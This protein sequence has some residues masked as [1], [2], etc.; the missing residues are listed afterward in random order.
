MNRILSI[1]AGGIFAALLIVLTVGIVKNNGSR[2]RE[3]DETSSTVA[4]TSAQT[5]EITESFTDFITDVT[6]EISDTTASAVSEFTATERTVSAVSSSATQKTTERITSGTT[7]KKTTEKITSETT[8]KKTTASATTAEPVSSSTTKP[9]VGTYEYAYAGFNPQY[10]KITDAN[11]RTV[12]VNRHYIIDK[13]YKP[14]LANSVT[15]DPNSKLLD[16]R[17]AP[18]Y[19]KMYLAA[20]ADGIIL[21]PLSGYRSYDLQHTNFENKITKY[22]NQGYSR[23][24]ATQEAAKIILPPGTSEHNAGLAMDIISLEQSFE[25]TAA[26]KWLM[27]NAADYGFILRYPKNKESVTEIVYEPWHW[28]YVGVDTAKAI[29]ASGKCM[30]EYFGL[31]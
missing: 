27:N 9:A 8:A 31:A 20:K 23:V 21:T 7:A 10:I 30:E 19:N 26:F 13:N 5:S 3:K 29:K 28:R 14:A 17:V 16:S 18:Y 25:N 2:V 4:D 12:I 6:E 15:G 1:I 22:V 24:K 11:W